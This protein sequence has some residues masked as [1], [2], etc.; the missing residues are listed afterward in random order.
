M[1]NEWKSPPNAPPRRGCF[2]MR[3][4][5]VRSRRRLGVAVLIWVRS[6]L[7]RYPHLLTDIVGLTA[8]GFAGA[9]IADGEWSDAVAGLLIFGLALLGSWVRSVETEL[10]RLVSRVDLSH[11]ELQE[12]LWDVQDRLEALGQRQ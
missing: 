10:D 8:A 7:R 12:I 6:V 11:K 3:A 4:A 1:A 9:A 2:C 5:Y